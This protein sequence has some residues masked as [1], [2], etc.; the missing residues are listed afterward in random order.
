[1]RRRI[2]VVLLLSIAIGV[3]A[4]GVVKSKT[5]IST[6]PHCDALMS[7][8]QNHPSPIDGAVNPEM[9]PDEVAYSV[10]FRLISNRQEGP[11]KNRARAYIRRALAWSDS[12]EPLML[13]DKMIASDQDVE[14]LLN[15]AEEFH[16]RVKDLDDQALTIKERTWPE[17]TPDA[18]VQLNQLQQQHEALVAEIS[19]SL[20]TRLSVDGMARLRAFINGHMKHNMKIIP[21]PQ[22]PPSY[23]PPD[24]QN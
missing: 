12:H 4:I 1:M 8:Q 20:P 18:L 22:P 16:R 23:P 3:G 9:I 6:S 21:G 14:S 2:L 10:I 5:K 17:P 7:T 13:N 19:T 15:A 24:P 11:E